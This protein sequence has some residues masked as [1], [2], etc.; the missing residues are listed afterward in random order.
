MRRLNWIP[1]LSISNPKHSSRLNYSC[2][3]RHRQ[4]SDHW[5]VKLCRNFS[6]RD[7]T[8]PTLNLDSIRIRMETWWGCKCTEFEIEGHK[9]LRNPQIPQP[10]QP[11]IHADYFQGHVYIRRTPVA[12]SEFHPLK[13][14][15]STETLGWTSQEAY[16]HRSL[17]PASHHIQD[18]QNYHAPGT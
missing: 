12:M 10:Q 15:S 2:Q 18:H 6:P 7:K 4:H 8:K 5:D 17:V 9:V 14:K 13:F 3:K 16:R 1:I 11:I